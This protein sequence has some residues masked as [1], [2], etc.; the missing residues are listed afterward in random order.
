MS[1]SPPLAAPMAIT[2]ACTPIARRQRLLPASRTTT[3]GTPTSP[4]CRSTPTAQPGWRRPAATTSLRIHP[5]FGGPYGIPYTIVTGSPP[6]GSGDL[7]LRRRER[8]GALPARHR[9]DDRGRQR[10]ARP[11]ARQLHLQALRDLGH[12]TDGRTWLDAGSGAVYDL[13]SDA[14]RPDGWTSADAAGLPILPGLLRYDEVESG[15]STTRSASPSRAPTA[16]HLWPA[17]HDAGSAS[18]RQPAAD[19]R[20]LPAQGELPDARPAP[21]HRRRSSTP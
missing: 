2:T 7:R 12:P 10:R 1:P 19:G 18:D 20:A 11:R 4:S 21:R 17:R 14:L 8:Q 16:A 6:E 3:S 15:T 9:H 5:D 13:H